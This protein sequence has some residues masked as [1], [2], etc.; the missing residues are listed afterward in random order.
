MPMGCLD[1][2]LVFGDKDDIMAHMLGEPHNF[3]EE[4][5]PIICPILTCNLKF[6]SVGRLHQHLKVGKHNQP[7][8]TCAKKFKRVRVIF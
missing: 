4:E 2:N 5:E 1:C 3:N 6:S 8:P 7:C